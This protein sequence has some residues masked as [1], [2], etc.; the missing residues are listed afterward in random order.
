MQNR[1]SARRRA[2]AKP[3]TDHPFGATEDG[4]HVCQIADQIGGTVRVLLA[5]LITQCHALD[6]RGLEAVLRLVRCGWSA[7]G[8]AD[9]GHAVQFMMFPQRI[10]WALVVAN[11]AGGIGQLREKNCPLSG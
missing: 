10:C 5:F 2:D 8:F 3:D 7:G 6:R 4:N 11:P 1:T 9:L